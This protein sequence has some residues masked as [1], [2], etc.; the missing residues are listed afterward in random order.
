MCAAGCQMAIFASSGADRPPIQVGACESNWEESRPCWANTRHW[1]DVVLVR[2][3]AALSNKTD[4]R[5]MAYLVTEQ[6]PAPTVLELR[7]FLKEKLS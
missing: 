5:L 6:E 7:N 4:K 3:V 1:S 2:G